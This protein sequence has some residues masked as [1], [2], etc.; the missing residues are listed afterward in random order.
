MERQY[1]T[2]GARFVQSFGEEENVTKK[3]IEILEKIGEGT[4]CVCYSVKVGEGEDYQKMVMK[5]FYPRTGAKCSYE[6]E[7]DNLELRI[8]DYESSGVSALGDHFK[9]AYQLQNKLAMQTDETM[10]VVVRPLFKHF[11][12]SSMLVLYEANYGK[13]MDKYIH[14][15][16]DVLELVRFL[17]QAAEAMQKIHDAG[18]VLMD[19]K[20]ENIMWSEDKR[21]V[22]FFDFDASVGIREHIPMENLRYDAREEL[23]PPELAGVTD[24]GMLSM[25]LE[26]Q[27]DIFGLGCI[28]YYGIMG[29]YPPR[30]AE[31][32]T[33]AYMEY[34][35]AIT[36]RIGSSF[37]EEQKEE[38]YDI[39]AGCL[40]VSVDERISSARELAGRLHELYD[41]VIQRRKAE[42]NYYILSAYAMDKYPLYDYCYKCGRKKILDVSIIG[43]SPIVDAFVKHIFSCA[44]ML[45]TDMHI[46]LYSGEAEQYMK[47]LV[48]SCPQLRTTARFYLDGAEWQNMEG[49][50]LDGRITQEPLA[51]FY[52][53]SQE[54]DT[55]N[56]GQIVAGKGYADSGYYLIVSEPYEGNRE[57]AE[58]LARCL[59]SGSGRVFIGYGVDS[60]NYRNLETNVKAGMENENL[61]LGVFSCT[62]YIDEMAEF[63]RD[64]DGKK[65]IYDIALDIHTFY[66]KDWNETAD[67]KSIL[68]NFRSPDQYGNYYNMKSSIRCALSIPY[69]MFLVGLVGNEAASS[70]FC[71]AVLDNTDSA[72]NKLYLLAYMEHVSWLCF[73]I[74]EG[75]SLPEDKQ[76][77]GYLYRNGND[78]RNKLEK[79]HPCIC[80][81]RPDRVFLLEDLPHD[82][83]VDEAEKNSDLDMGE[84]SGG[85][86]SLDRMSLKLHKI[87]ED[88][89]EDIRGQVDMLLKV[90]EQQV[91]VQKSAREMYVLQ[92]QMRTM[93]EFMF[94]GGAN[95]N[96]RWKKNVEKYC[97][98][99][100][101]AR[102]WDMVEKVE[103]IDQTMRVVKERNLFHDYKKSDLTIIKAIP[104]L[105]QKIR[106]Q[107]IS[108]II[109]LPASGLEQLLISTI[110]IEPDRL[111]IVDD[112]TGLGDH[113][114]KIKEFLKDRGLE[115]VQVE[116]MTIDGIAEIIAKKEMEPCNFLLDVTGCADPSLVI[117]AAFKLDGIVRAEYKNGRLE[118][119]D[120]LGR[121]GRLADFYNQPRHLR[122]EEL[123]NLYGLQV[124]FHDDSWYL[125]GTADVYKN[126]WRA[127]NAVLFREEWNGEICWSKVTG[128]FAE[129]KEKY[130]QVLPVTPKPEESLENHQLQINRANYEETGMK[131]AL[132]E[133]SW[134]GLLRSFS[135]FYRGEKVFLGMQCSDEMW[136]QIEMMHS[137]AKDGRMRHRFIVLR[138]QAAH[139]ITGKRGT[140]KTSY[141]YDACLQL[142]EEV[143]EEYLPPM[144]DREE[145]SEIF[146]Y[147]MEILQAYGRE[148]ILMNGM[149]WE[150]QKILENERNGSFVQKTD[151]GKLQISCSFAS[152]GVMHCLLQENRVMQMYVYYTLMHQACFDDIR[153]DVELLGRSVPD[154]EDTVYNRVDIVC[155]RKLQ[156]YFIFCRQGDPAEYIKDMYLN[157]FLYK[158]VKMILICAQN[159]SSVREEKDRGDDEALRAQGIYVLDRKAVG[160]DVNAIEEDRLLNAICEIAGLGK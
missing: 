131:S 7:L 59:E 130:C 110:L 91:N 98:E 147:I 55:K 105:L 158:D 144:W 11:Q 87:C 24:S 93:C 77:E 45:N 92:K 51:C 20:P 146:T 43:M 99:L 102:H 5:Q 117:K 86:D 149:Q 75:Y 29:K 60:S 137:A 10:D 115:H 1:Y 109:K 142:K 124:S 101:N 123:F 68:E 118:N 143:P 23:R 6:Y 96:A 108:T 90:L 4:S 12:G 69:K 129:I 122:L 9:A 157:R 134:I 140:T 38:L 73:M 113:L 19:I 35:K 21:Q 154:L 31:N 103:Q 116:C 126:L 33:N 151:T 67:R 57:I 155:T 61:K 46:R 85:Y 127:Y 22:R 66:T 70:G 94:D 104:L 139:P 136:T 81:S 3:K 132:E 64:A 82:K 18:Y 72:K 13:S 150:D 160:S 97:M 135:Q 47:K 95:A 74:M 37:S 100:K 133:F 148:K 53:Y 16:V 44:Q 52:I 39:I 80:G 49:G 112:E 54:V 2:P 107:H 76:L 114:P 62:A 27:L 26:P 152:V 120:Q 153:M 30:D 138:D 58:V 8:K 156:A 14:G 89:T 145:Q 119:L 48:D 84:I 125:T 15:S 25:F 111:V 106:N 128:L 34:H 71:K 32:R 88:K 159:A 65:S 141:L 50:N 83:W 42:T 17:E 78:H 79:L 28:M 56:I 121:R 41:K 40:K 36:D 63:E